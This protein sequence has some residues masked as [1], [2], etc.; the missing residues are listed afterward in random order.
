MDIQFS[1]YIL[2]RYSF[3]EDSDNNSIAAISSNGKKLVIVY[4]NELNNKKSVLFDLSSFHHIML[5][6]MD[7][8]K[9]KLPRRVFASF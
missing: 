4:I 8:C 9:G 3:I 1:K 5:Q 2:P 7:H 6:K